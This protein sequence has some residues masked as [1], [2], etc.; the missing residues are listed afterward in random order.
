MRTCI[1][2]R[3][4]RPASELIRVA[5]GLDGRIVAE[6]QAPGRGAWLCP[7]PTCGLRARKTRAF[8]RALRLSAEPSGLDDLMSF[9]DRN[10]TNVRD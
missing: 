8:A 4:R 2:C 1:G 10:G 9:L 6:R 3:Q 7:N 5:I